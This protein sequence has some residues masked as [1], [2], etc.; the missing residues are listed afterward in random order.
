MSQR[1]D[2]AARRRAARQRA[3][4]GLSAQPESPKPVTVQRSERP[5]SRRVA[6]TPAAPKR[7]R[8][9]L[10]AGG[11][12][13]LAL[14]AAGLFFTGVIGGPDSSVTPSAN[15]AAT[16]TNSS[17]APSAV[18]HADCPTSQPAALASDQTRDVTLH[19]ELGDISIEV[20]G[21]LSPIAAGNF[22]ALASCNFYDGL[23][24]H[25]TAT[26]P[27]G[28]PF[29][30]QGGDPNGDGTGG[31]GYTIA[32]EPVTSAYVRGTV[33]MARTSAPNSAGSQFFIVLDDR[34]GEVLS[35]ANTYQIFG[36]VTGGMDVVDAIYAA[37]GGA[38]LPAIPVRIDATTVA[39]P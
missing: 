5:K 29:V 24:F 10:A 34:D 20:D 17:P 26:L 25:R 3:A 1:E 39:T 22:V 31:P 32:D 9:L 37:S 7:S 13:L 4:A 14:L 11:A 33:A 35:S 15:P 23:T 2:R 30:I 36:S 6:S 12:L 18:A 8:L 28:T 19:T 21:V 16:F 27:D 38:E